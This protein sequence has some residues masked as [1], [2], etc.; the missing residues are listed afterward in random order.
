MNGLLKVRSLRTGYP[1]YFRLS[2]AL[3]YKRYRT[4]LTS[5]GQQ[6]TKAKG[7]D[8]IWRQMCSSLLQ[9]DTKCMDLLHQAI[10]T[11]WSQCRG[12]QVKGSVS[13]SAPTST[14]HASCKYRLSP[15]LLT[16]QLQMGGSHD[17]LLSSIICQY[18]SEHSG[19]HLRLPLYCKI[20]NKIK[21]IDGQPHK[22]MHG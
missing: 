1:V 10:L 9:A 2:A 3:F 16:Y 6:S 14:S 15:V 19:K 7:T 5:T 18:H 13:Q 22:E 17:H 11:A 8:L 4:S 20:K 21:D 12:R